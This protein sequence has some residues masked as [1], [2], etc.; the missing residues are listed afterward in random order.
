MEINCTCFR[1]KALDT[2]ISYG[3]D[4]H[5]NWGWTR[6]DCPCNSTGSSWERGWNWWQ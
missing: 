4:F 6:R 5:V 2:E 3:S 1:A